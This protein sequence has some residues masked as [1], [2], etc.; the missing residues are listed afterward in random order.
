M[1]FD[2]NDLVSFYATP[3]GYFTRRTLAR[4]V[5]SRWESCA[6]LAVMGLGFGAPY[7]ERFRGEARRTL[8]FMPAAQGVMAWPSDGPVASALVEADMLPLPDGSIDR[9][10][11]IHA[12][13]MAEDSNAVLEEIW[14]V[15]APGGRFLLVVPSRRGV[16]ASIDGTPFG[17]GR[18]YSK[19][20][21]REL[22]RE[23][24]FTPIYS[25]EALY[26]PPFK[27]R[28]FLR[29]TPALERFGAFA[30]L[31]FPGVHIVEA[32]KQLYRPVTVRR[33]ARRQPLALAPALAPSARRDAGSLP[34]GAE[35]ASCS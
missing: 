8:A 29:A 32:T 19:G 21:L 28:F 4:V 18:P 33:L 30:G 24:L 23:T 26:A 17:F 31:P 25:G 20:Q 12:L 22:L 6:G 5:N 27:G 13:E 35:S 2:V 7:L 16:W 10:L 34:V 1:P 11:A 3:L 14:R 15:L 9:V